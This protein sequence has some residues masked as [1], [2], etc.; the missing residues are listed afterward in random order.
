LN[1]KNKGVAGV[2]GVTGVQELQELQKFRES[3]FLSGGVR[4]HIPKA[5]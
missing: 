2:T 1:R 4:I 5:F 3:A